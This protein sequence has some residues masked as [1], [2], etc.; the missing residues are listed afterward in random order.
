MVIH[1]PHANHAN[2]LDNRV[3]ELANYRRVRFHVYWDGGGKR[4]AMKGVI[5]SQI[6]TRE[7]NTQRR[8]GTGDSQR[9]NI[10]RPAS[11]YLPE[12]GEPPP[13]SFAFTLERQIAAACEH[14]CRLR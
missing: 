6:T 9:T 5:T 7:R 3:E 12:K 2:A 8:R 4:D 13:G 1:S 10:E 14:T 11:W